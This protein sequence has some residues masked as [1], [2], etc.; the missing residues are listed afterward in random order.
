LETAPVLQNIE[1]KIFRSVRAAI[2]YDH[3]DVTPADIASIE[4]L[5]QPINVELIPAEKLVTK[6]DSEFDIIGVLGQSALD[7][8]QAYL[9]DYNSLKIGFYSVETPNVPLRGSAKL[10]TAAVTCLGSKSLLDSLKTTVYHFYES[11]TLPSLL[12]IDLADVDSIARGVGVSFNLTGD[13]SDEVIF[14]L[15]PQCYIARSALLHFTCKR[16][17]TLEEVY[18]ISKAISTRKV[19]API[20][21][22][23]LSRDQIKMYKRI[24]LKMG[25]RISQDWERSNTSSRISLTGIL[26][27]VKPQYFGWM[28]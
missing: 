21:S 20:A 16:D 23:D 8:S 26:F 9:P 1:R 15:P 5:Y 22:E 2:L 17:V 25:L 10:L 7:G 3:V 18:R 11:L 19:S 28:P 14:R 13:N 4:K 12:N 24:R 27:G 6:F